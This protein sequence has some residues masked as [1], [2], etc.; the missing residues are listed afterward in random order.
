MPATLDE[1][2][3]W[4]DAASQS[5]LVPKDFRGK[6]HDILVALQLGMELGLPP[7]TALQSICVINGRPTV[8]G[9]TQLALVITSRP[10][11]GHDEYFEL[12]TGEVDPAN[13]SQVLYQRVD[14]LTEQDWRN[15]ETRAVCRFDRKDR[16]TPII[17]TFSVGKAKKAGLLTK[18]GPWQTYPERMLRLRARSFAARDAFPDVLRGMVTAEEVRDDPTIIEQSRPLEVR[19]ERTVQ[20]RSEQ[21]L[22]AAPADAPADTLGPPNWA[23]RAPAPEEAP[24]IDMPPVPDIQIEGT[25][26]AIDRPLLGGATVTLTNGRILL[27]MAD[28]YSD[29]ALTSLREHAADKHALIFACRALADGDLR[30]MDFRQ[31]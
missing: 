17:R 23:E 5:S 26:Q 30:I 6:P 13:P 31:A 18:D 12:T 9:D 2:W 11:K 28:D 21:Q 16:E 25:I 27:L 14:S 3:R 19:A 1:A 10:Y 22:A 8:W 20:R 7:M 15:D 24:R 4:S 29:D